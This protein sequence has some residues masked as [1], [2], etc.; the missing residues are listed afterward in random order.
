MDDSVYSISHLR[1]RIQFDSE[2]NIWNLQS[3]EKNIMKSCP[4]VHDRMFDIIVVLTIDN[5]KQSIKEEQNS[6]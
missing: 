1:N 3:Q 5:L 6:I 4:Y 2:V